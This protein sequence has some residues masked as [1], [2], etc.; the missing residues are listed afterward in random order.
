MARKTAKTAKTDSPATVAPKADARSGEYLA[1]AREAGI[2]WTAILEATG[3]RSA[4][5]LRATL[6]RY[7]LSAKG[8]SE[9]FPVEY[10]K[11]APIAK[12]TGEAIVELR[13][14]KGEG[15]PRIAAR[16]G[17]S[18][19]KV[20]D[21]YAKAGGISPD[22]RVYV[23]SAGRTLV[24]RPGESVRL[25]VPAP[26]ESDAK[27]AKKAAKVAR[28]AAKAKADAKAAKKA[29]KAAKREARA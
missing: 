18:V 21:L 13:D 10:A 20:R 3:A 1:T 6:A 17:L 15:F 9:R 8:A 26:V 5:P 19:A 16:T 29:A 11:V 27:A 2:V 7:L 22:G 28:K 4:I 14:A 23:G 25:D 24:T 12:A